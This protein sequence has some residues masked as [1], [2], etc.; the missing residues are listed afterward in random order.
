MKGPAAAS[1]NEAAGRVGGPEP[2]SA[3][4]WVSARPGWRVPAGP[5]DPPDGLAQWNCS[6]SVEPVRARVSAFGLSAVETWS[7]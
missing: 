3:A 2:E 7:K 5:L 6:A 4:P 1:L